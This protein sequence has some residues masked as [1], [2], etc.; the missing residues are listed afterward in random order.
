VLGQR[1]C[2]RER[3]ESGGPHVYVRQTKAS[4]FAWLSGGLGGFFQGH[5]GPQPGDR[6][7]PSVWGIWIGMGDEEGTRAGLWSADGGAIHRGDTLSLT[8]LG[9]ADEARQKQRED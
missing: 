3:V 6:V 5:Q 7:R 1:L 8:Q 9:N 2:R 4:G